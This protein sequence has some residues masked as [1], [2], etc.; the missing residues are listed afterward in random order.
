MNELTSG[1]S[2][3]SLTRLMTQGHSHKLQPANILNLT[4]NVSHSVVIVSC[5]PSSG[6]WL[7]TRLCPCV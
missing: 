2:Q 3:Q 5:K 4:I 1:I 7:Y 6:G